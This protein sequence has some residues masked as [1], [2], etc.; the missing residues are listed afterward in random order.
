VATVGALGITAGTVGI[1]AGAA[2]ATTTTGGF[3]SASIHVTNHDDSGTNSN[4]TTSNWA[5]D[6]YGVVLHLSTGGVVPNGNCP[7]IS[8]RP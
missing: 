3:T 8:T 1:T 4:G 6:D 5:L 2:S 7:G